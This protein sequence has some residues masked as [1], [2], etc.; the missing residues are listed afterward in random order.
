[1]STL[2]EII[3]AQLTESNLDLISSKLGTDRGKTRAAIGAALPS[4]IAALARNGSTPEGAA[5]LASAIDRDGHDGSV[6]DN[7]QQFIG[8]DQYQDR[9]SGP[10]ILNHL[11]GGKQS[12]VAAG[13][14]QAT[15]L[16]ADSSGK[17]MQMLA[18]MVLGA[19]GKQ[20]REQ[21][22]DASSLMG[23]F[24][25][26]KESVEKQGGSLIG[27]LLD[28]DGDGDFDLNDVGKLA[29]NKLFGE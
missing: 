6:L 4:L 15:G 27:R 20:K 1:M 17:L 12:Q 9:R 8:E 2:M 10:G 13:I 5:G 22:L 19:L 16:Q 23:F 21:G 29:M 11:L 25:Q 24:G 7:L 28:Q 14:G 18:P 26:E 3:S